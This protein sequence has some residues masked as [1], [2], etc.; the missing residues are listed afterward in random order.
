MLINHLA[1]AAVSHHFARQFNPNV[2]HAPRDFVPTELTNNVVLE[3]GAGKGKHAMLYAAANPNAQ[4][5]A[6]ERTQDKFTAFA[7]SAKEQHLPNLSPIHADAVAWV[8]HGVLPHSLSQVFILYPNPEPKNKNQ[9]FLHM[10]FFEFLL[11]RLQY[12]GQITL[13]SN[14]GEYITEA[15]QLLQSV[16]CL[17]FIKTDIASTSARTH[18]EIKYLTRGE[19]C[20]ELVITKPVGYR[21]RFDDWQADNGGGA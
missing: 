5:I 7:K 3:I 6:I 4:I 19:R 12:G 8:V 18:F 1:N 14:I 16:W 10:P 11:S 21:T 13:A 9:R 20:Q 15:E 17:P 2:I